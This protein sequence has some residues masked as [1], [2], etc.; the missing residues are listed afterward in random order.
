MH[1]GS[2]TRNRYLNSFEAPSQKCVV[3]TKRTKELDAEEAGRH[4]PPPRRGTQAAIT[5]SGRSGTPES[6]ERR[7]DMALPVPPARDTGTEANPEAT[8]H[9]A[10]QLVGHI[11]RNRGTRSQRQTEELLQTDRDQQHPTMK[12]NAW[13][14]ARPLRN[15]RYHW[16]NRQ[17]SSGVSALGGRTDADVMT[18]MAV[19]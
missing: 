6:S 17:N 5:G 15:K 1:K 8:S 14:T 9:K 2:L 19:S 10:R 16:G 18:L 7:E 4:R 13:T 12:G 11:W 3:T